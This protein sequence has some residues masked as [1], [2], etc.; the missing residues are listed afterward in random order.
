MKRKRKHLEKSGTAAAVSLSLLLGLFGGMGTAAQEASP[1]YAAEEIP[2][3]TAA[4]L[5][6]TTEELTRVKRSDRLYSVDVEAPDG[7]GRIITLPTP[8]KYTDDR[9]EV[10]WID[11]A[12]EPV[13]DIYSLYSGYDYRNA[14]NRFTVYYSQ[15][16]DAGLDLDGDFRLSA[17]VPGG[18]R[19]LSVIR[20]TTHWY[21]PMHLAL[22]AAW[23]R[24]TSVRA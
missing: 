1:Y 24:A 10:R 3:S 20:W 8:L 11:T 23:N 2:S 17:V 21:I 4:A 16:P 13:G 7:S 14:A 5:E 19:G 18:H 9:G 15:W 22:S 6:L 12:M